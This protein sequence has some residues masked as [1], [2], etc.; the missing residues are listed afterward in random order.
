MKKPPINVTKLKDS[1]RAITIYWEKEDK[2]IVHWEMY[3]EMDEALV[4]L[5]FDALVKTYKAMDIMIK[6]ACL[7]S[8]ELRSKLAKME[9][10]TIETNRI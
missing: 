7:Y 6:D 3:N 4:E 2:F 9:R 5:S 8:K 10:S 1:D